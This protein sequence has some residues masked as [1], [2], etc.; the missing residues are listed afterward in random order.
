MCILFMHMFF[1]AYIALA[2]FG[3]LVY[4]HVLLPK[5]TSIWLSKKVTLYPMKVIPDIRQYVY[6]KYMFKRESQIDTCAWGSLVHE[7][8]IRPVISVS[9]LT[10]IIR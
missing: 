8:I 4:A 5:T 10:W 3:Y 9:T 7:G 2:G 6:T 1:H